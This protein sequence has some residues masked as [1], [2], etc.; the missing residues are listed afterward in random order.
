MA[1][2]AASWQTASIATTRGLVASDIT[3]ASESSNNPLR[4]VHQPHVERHCTRMHGGTPTPH[5]RQ[6][7]WHFQNPCR[8]SRH[9]P[10]APARPLMAL[11]SPIVTRGHCEDQVSWRGQ[12]WTGQGME[13]SAPG[14]EQDRNDSSTGAGLEQAKDWTQPQDGT[15][16]EIGSGSRRQ[17]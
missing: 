5:A 16:T 1:S 17:V 7:L 15:R 8:L 12:G 9:P 2:A 11:R 6:P 3:L 13:D 10:R 4:M 14:W